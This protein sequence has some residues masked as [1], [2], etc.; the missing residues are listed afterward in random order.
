MEANL[1]FQVVLNA[2]LLKLLKIQI[3][4][5]KNNTLTWSYFPELG[6][7]TRK[8]STHPKRGTND[9]KNVKCSRYMV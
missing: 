7:I 4:V 9:F 3:F 2:P 1:L 8:G 6:S 5:L